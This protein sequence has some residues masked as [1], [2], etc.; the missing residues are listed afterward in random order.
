MQLGKVAITLL[1]I[2][3]IQAQQ[4]ARPKFEVTSIKLHDGA[5]SPMVS[6][7][8]GGFKTGNAPTRLLIRAAYQVRDFQIFGAPDWIDADRYDI[9]AKTEIKEPIGPQ[10]GPM[11]QALLA[12]RFKLRFHRETRELPVYVLMVSK[13]GSRLQTAKAGSCVPWDGKTMPPRTPPGQKSPV[14]CGFFN[15]GIDAWLNRTL[16]GVGVGIPGLVG[17]ISQKLDRVVIDKTGLTGKYDIHLVWDRK[18]TAEGKAA[19]ADD[20]AGPSLFAALEDQ[21]GLTLEPDKAPVKV[22]VI[23]H[24][25][26]P[27]TRTEPRP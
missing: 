5:G 9:E 26:R 27:T 3:G 22:I 25:E 24:I 11:F 18:V 13:H 8:P 19:S 10:L 21:L 7:F 20:D 17:E 4:A 23:D 12:D 16:A 2:P 15:R 1:F 6:G 14:Y